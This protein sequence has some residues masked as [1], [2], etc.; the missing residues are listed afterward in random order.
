MN[1]RT[2][3]VGIFVLVAMTCCMD[4]YA[5]D[6]G[7]SAWGDFW[8]GVGGFLYNALPWNWGSWMGK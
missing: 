4:A 1:K 3:I 7:S 8:N 5:A 6:G 2:L